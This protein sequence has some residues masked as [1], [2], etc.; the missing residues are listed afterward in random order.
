MHFNLAAANN[1]EYQVGFHDENAI[2]VFPQLLV[3]RYPPKL[4]MLLKSSDSVVELVYKRTRSTL[5]VLSN[6]VEDRYQIVLRTW[7]VAQ[8]VS[9]RHGIVCGV[10][11]SFACA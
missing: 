5:A 8:C 4:R 1:V 11:T 3:T 9:S 10:W 7:E 2:P 6:V